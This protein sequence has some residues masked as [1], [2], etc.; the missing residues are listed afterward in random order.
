MAFSFSVSASPVTSDVITFLSSSVSLMFRSPLS[1]GGICSEV[2]DTTSLTV[3]SER[4]GS[5]DGISWSSDSS[6]AISL[7]GS[8][9]VSGFSGLSTISSS[10]PTPLNEGSGSG[11]I[12]SFVSKVLTVCCWALRYFLSQSL[13]NFPLR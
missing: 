12:S 7:S 3:F 9:S 10:F 2:R 8:W 1:T 11:S 13:I 4:G 5:S 6:A